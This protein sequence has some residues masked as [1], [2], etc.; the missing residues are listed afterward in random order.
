MSHDVATRAAT[1]TLPVSL[2]LAALSLAASGIL[3]AA[4]LPWHPDILRH[5][6]DQA[7]RAFPAWAALHAAGALAAVLSLV[8]ASGVVAAH[9]DRLGR[10]GRSALL[11]SFVGS[12][13]ATALFAVE[14]ITFPVLAAQS[15]QL[16]APG[17]SLTGSRL[18]IGLAGLAVAWPVGL[19]L[20]GVAAARA[21][22]FPVQAGVLLAL[23]ATA[24][25][26]LYVPFVPVAGPLAVVAFGVAEVCWGWLLWREGG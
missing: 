1:P 6:L 10:L 24:F 2:R 15:P 8:G 11:V 21:H 22:L 4:A 16:L 17:G 14:A 19:L 5:P 23:T 12:L 7:V 9:D 18:L 26:V 3:V 25:L 13:A 20:L